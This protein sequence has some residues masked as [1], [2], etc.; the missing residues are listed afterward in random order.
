MTL[1]CS[2]RTWHGVDT[3]RPA[4]RKLKDKEMGN[5]IDYTEY[6]SK[7]FKMWEISFNDSSKRNIKTANGLVLFCKMRTVFLQLVNQTYTFIHRVHFDKDECCQP[8]VWVNLIVV[9]QHLWEA[10][11]KDIFRKLQGCISCGTCS[12][13]KLTEDHVLTS[14]YVKIFRTVTR[15]AVKKSVWMKKNVFDFP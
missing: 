14:A 1:L 12:Y 4:K 6:G 15:N 2:V 10:K 3:S 8:T 13:P 9:I 7:F 5:A 11:E